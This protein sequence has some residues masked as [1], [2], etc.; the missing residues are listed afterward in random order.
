MK[1]YTY[2]NADEVELL[3]N[4]KSLG[5]KR[6]NTADPKVRNRIVWEN[7][8]YEPGKIEAV[9]YR[10]GENRPVARHQLSTSGKAVRLVAEADNDEWKADGLDLQHILIEAVDSKDRRDGSASDMLTSLW[11]D[12]RK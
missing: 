6:N 7:I 11:M 2:T 3:L 1:L 5:K 10:S 12:P 9:A 8:S 4:G